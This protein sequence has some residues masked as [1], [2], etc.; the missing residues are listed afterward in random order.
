M[1]IEFVDVLAD[2]PAIYEAWT[3]WLRETPEDEWRTKPMPDAVANAA[4]DAMYALGDADRRYASLLKVFRAVDREWTKG[5][6]C[7]VCAHA[8]DP[9]YD[10][11]NNC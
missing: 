6:R 5:L 3:A 2:V 4:I 11:T 9:T 7:G 10:H 1:S 8:D